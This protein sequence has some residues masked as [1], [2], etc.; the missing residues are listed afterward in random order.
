MAAA[1]RGMRLALAVALSAVALIGCSSK[2][3]AREPAKLVSIKDAQV[4]PDDVWT[5]SIGGGSEGY[6]SGFRLALGEDALFA[7]SLDGKVYALNPK[8]G[9]IIWRVRT[10]ARVISGPGISDNLV[11]VGTL[12]GEIIA[13]KRADGK[14]VWRSRAPSEALGPPVGS[15]NVVVAKSS[16]GREYGLDAV[17]GERKWS[18]DRYEPSL[19]LRGVSAPLII[20]NRVYTGLDNG[21]LAVLN[22][23]DGSPVWEQTISVATGR[24]VLDQLTDIDS[25]LLAG[26]D[27]LY[28][29]SYG[30]DLA[31]I[32]YNTGDSRWRRGVKSY[33]GMVQGGDKLFVTDD[34]GTVWALDAASGAAAWKQQ[35]LKYRRLSP[36][37]YFKGYVVV[38]DYKGYL[39]WLSPADGK[40]VGRT[41]LGSGPIVTPPVAGAD[42]LYIMDMAGKLRAFDVKPP[43]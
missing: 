9:D 16:D 36:P 25:D 23:I 38:G 29:V 11:L 7:A 41:R 24:S 39:H 40:I 14:E 35:D 12:D 37:A 8:T 3:K 4:R 26:T 32:D 17:T 1:G 2:G 13:L 30:G 20:G 31:L 15:G 21:K 22:L 42:L 43:R 33:T 18:F 10:K 34:D 5:R 6:Y 28:V 19:T 27:G